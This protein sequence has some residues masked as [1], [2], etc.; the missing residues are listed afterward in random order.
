MG[1]L[2]DAATRKGRELFKQASLALTRLLVHSPQPLL[3]ARLVRENPK[4]RLEFLLNS[5]AQAELAA[6]GQHN[7]QRTI[8]GER[9]LFHKCPNQRTTQAEVQGL[10]GALPVLVHAE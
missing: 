2:V 10:H 8:D 9:D 4:A 5:V 6:L 3:K 1:L 7:G